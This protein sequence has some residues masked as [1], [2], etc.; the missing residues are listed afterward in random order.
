MFYKCFKFTNCIQIIVHLMK[1]KYNN[2]TCFDEFLKVPSTYIVIASNL[3]FKFDVEKP[4]I[5][6]SC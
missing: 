6:L 2:K 1:I 4:I 3:T 5:L